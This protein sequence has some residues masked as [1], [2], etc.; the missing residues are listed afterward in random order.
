MAK[1]TELTDRENNVL[2]PKTIT[3]QVYTK[4]GVNLDETL[5]SFVVGEEVIDEDTFEGFDKITREA[6]KKDLFDDIWKE[7]VGI[8]GNVDH[9]HMEDGILKPYHL[10]TLWFTYKEAIAIYDVGTIDSSRI[11]R[12][13][14][15]CKIKTNLP[16]KLSTNIQTGGY[17]TFDYAEDL[18][19]FSNIEILNLDV[20]GSNRVN[21]NTDCFKLGNFNDNFLTSDT[22][23]K[24]IGNIDLGQ[25]SALN[26]IIDCPNLEEISI[27]LLN[28][29]VNFSKCP[30]LN[31]DSFATMINNSRGNTITLTVHPEVYAKLTDTSNTEW[32]NLLTLAATK[33]I[34]FATTN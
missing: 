23:K 2:Y 34:T 26:S 14:Y 25:G 8:Y 5:D 13:F 18:I 7:A 1:L 6:I 33:N 11:G 17:L 4:Q 27:I 31:L 3:S 29:S 15:R 10:N 9:T 21:I 30:K 19:R 22:L 16:I 20:N 12:R 24:V 32:N 28:R